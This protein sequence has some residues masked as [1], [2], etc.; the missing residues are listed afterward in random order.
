MEVHV[1]SR[2]QLKKLAKKVGATHVLSLTDVASKRPFLSQSFNK[3]NWL[4]LRFEDEI[5]ENKLNAPTRNHVATILDWGSRLPKDAVV[6]H[7]EAGVSRSTAA[8]LALLVQR[9]GIDK[10]Q[11]CVNILLSVRPQACPNPVI[12]KF[13]DELLHCNGRLFVAAEKVAFEKVKSLLGE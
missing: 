8:A 6:V 9:H 12:S 10:I 1:C 11:E 5:E 7:C 13:A 3:A 4:W 2:S